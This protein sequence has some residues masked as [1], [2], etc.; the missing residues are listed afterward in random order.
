MR[1]PDVVVVGAGI[2]GVAAAWHLARDRRVVLVERGPRPASESTGDGVG[3]VRRLG[4]D[5]VERVLAIRTAEWL[6]SLGLPSIR[7]LGCAV[8]RAHE[9]TLGHDGAAALRAAGI[10]VEEGPP[11]PILRGVRSVWHVPDELAIEPPALCAEVARRAEQRGA[12]LRFG[13]AVGGLL[14][15]GDAV[16]GVQTDHGPLEADAVVLA[17]G[18]WSAALAASVGLDRRLTP[19]RRSVL[20]LEAPVPS[21]HPWVWVDDEGLYLRPEEERG[22][23][24]VSPCD[25]A[26]DRPSGAGSRRAPTPEAVA[27]TR[28]KL[29]RWAPALADAPQVDGWSGLRTFAPDRRPMLGADPERPGLW[30]V[31]GLGGF[32]LT[33]GWAAAEA[34]AGWMAGDAVPWLRPETVSPARRVSGRWP[35][36]PTGEAQRSVLIDSRSESA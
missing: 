8:A 14:R 23:W 16:V 24:L 12:E 22:T 3:M 21:G 29:A 17:T 1:N 18:A 30:W 6:G 28:S 32:G 35:I 34:V 9:A 5:P 36:R 33:C 31:A 11:P 26:V 7:R 27:L 4:D 10:R 2:G 25:E 19:L 15:R 20:R 13:V